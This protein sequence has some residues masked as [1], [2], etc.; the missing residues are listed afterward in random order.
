[1]WQTSIRDGDSKMMYEGAT[2]TTAAGRAGTTLGAF[3]LG[4]RLIEEQ[5]RLNGSPS[6][7]ATGLPE[8]N[9][10]GRS[11]FAFLHRAPKA[12]PACSRRPQLTFPS[13]AI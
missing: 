1:M 13:S 4:N 9:I 12:I 5:R 3:G 6:S 2:A 8:L 10:T 11:G 7:T